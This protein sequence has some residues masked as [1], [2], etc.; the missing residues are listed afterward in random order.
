MTEKQLMEK[1]SECLALDEQI[2]KLQKQKT[3]IYGEVTRH[4]IERAQLEVKRLY[5]V[6][7]GDKVMIQYRWFR[8]DAPKT[9]GPL[10]LAGFYMVNTYGFPQEDMIKLRFLKVKKDGMPSLRED[11]YPMLDIVSMEKVTE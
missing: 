9:I 8:G 4:Y 5:D 6:K 1:Q 10:V 7:E 3:E 11:N 2:A